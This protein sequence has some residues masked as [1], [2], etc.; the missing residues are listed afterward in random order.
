ML[1]ITLVSTLVVELRVIVEDQPA[2]LDVVAI[3]TFHPVHTAVNLCEVEASELLVI[4]FDEVLQFGSAPSSCCPSW[5]LKEELAGV[6]T[7]HDE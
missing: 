6:S 2:L 1:A 4:L 5:P 7:S 3:W